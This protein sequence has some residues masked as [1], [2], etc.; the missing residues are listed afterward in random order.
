MTF[1]H[2]G[3]GQI[4][5]SPNFEWFVYEHGSPPRT[6]ATLYVDQD[7]SE[8]AG[9]S[10]SANNLGQGSFYA[11]PGLY[12]LVPVVTPPG[13][14]YFPVTVMVAVNPLDVGAG[15]STNS[16]IVRALPFAFDTPDLATGAAIYTPTA[17]DWLLNAFFSIGI[18]WDGTTPLGDFGSLAFFEAASHGLFGTTDGGPG[19]E[20]SCVNMAI[21]DQ[22][23]WG[24]TVAPLG[25]LSLADIGAVGN[26][27]D[28]LQ[29]PEIDSVPVDQ[30]QFITIPMASVDAAAP[31]TPIRF[32]TD[33]PICVVVSQDG[34]TEGG[35]PGS[36][37][38]SAVLYL[39]TATPLT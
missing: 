27:W 17:G 14:N 25:N 31:A 6:P 35:D 28:F 15:G 38:G 29:V 9:N 33:D 24:D 26:A 5:G 7:K 30:Q 11:D 16:P 13:D 4:S 12:D 8:T 1:A 23:Y 37:Q 3:A 36:T 18:A 39:V 22:T 10:V 2:A 32:L 21:A 34:T 19:P 20:G